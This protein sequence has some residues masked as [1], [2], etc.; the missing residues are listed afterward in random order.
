MR[1]ARADLRV[2][3]KPVQ[4]IGYK[5]PVYVDAAF[6]DVV[7]TLPPP[8]E[9]RQKPTQNN[10]RRRPHYAVGQTNHRAARSNAVW[11]SARSSRAKSSP[12]STF[13]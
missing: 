12:P 10:W 4:V 9:R 13:S 11:S 7:A 5:Y 8:Q 2:T 3:T 6:Y 1:G